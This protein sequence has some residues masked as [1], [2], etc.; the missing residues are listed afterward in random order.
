[1]ET[2]G[3]SVVEPIKR[4]IPLSRAGKMESLCVFDQRWHSSSSRY[5]GVPY[6]FKSFSAC[7]ITARTSLTPAVTA[8]SFAIFAPVCAAI[9]LASVVFPQP[10]GPKNMLLVSVSVSMA[11]LKSLPLPTICS[12]PMNSSS[13]LGRILSASGARRLACAEKRSIP[14]HP[15]H[16][17]AYKLYSKT[18]LYTIGMAGV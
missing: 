7:S 12:C 9:T 14:N 8:L 6:S 15:F 11:R 10:G 16:I 4:T 1:M 2:I 13:V 17:C 18:A 5:V 3:F